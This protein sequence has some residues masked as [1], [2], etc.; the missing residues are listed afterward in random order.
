MGNF[1]IKIRKRSTPTSTLNQS[2]RSHQLNTVTNSEEV[3]LTGTIRD[4]NNSTKKPQQRETPR[5]GHRK[6][7]RE[8]HDKDRDLLKPPKNPDLIKCIK[9]NSERTKEKITYFDKQN[10]SPKGATTNSQHLANAKEK[11][12]QRYLRRLR[13]KTTPEAPASPTVR[14]SS[15]KKRKRFSTISSERNTIYGDHVDAADS[16][17]KRVSRLRT[18]ISNVISFNEPPR[19]HPTP[20]KIV[21]SVS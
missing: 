11:Q 18:S 13:R 9:W 19:R 16:V 7:K 5:A 10:T 15:F 14:S 17:D 20:S 21:G 6:A 8:N 2:N 12:F 4:T 3:E 1:L